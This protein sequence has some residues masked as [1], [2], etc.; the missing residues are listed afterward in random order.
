MHQLIAIKG[1][2]DGFTILRI[3]ARPH[4][5]TMLAQSLVYALLDVKDDS[6]RLSAQTK[7]FFGAID[8]VLILLAG[9][10]SI[11]FIRID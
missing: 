9:K 7:A 3:N 2:V 10:A 8:V 6:T 4:D 11:A 5:V 1:N